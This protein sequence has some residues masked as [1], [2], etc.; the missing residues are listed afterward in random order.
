VQGAGGAIGASLEFLQYLRYLAT[1]TGAVLIIDETMTSRL[2]YHGQIH[3]M[4]IEPDL[5]TLGKW[6]GGGMTFGAFGGKRDIMSMFDQDNGILAHSGT[7]N[8]NV[9][10]MTTGIAGMKIYDEPKVERLN[11]LG[12]L[13]KT[14]LEDILDRHGVSFTAPRSNGAV[15]NGVKTAVPKPKLY[16]CGVGSMLAIHFTGPEAPLL[17]SVFFHHLLQH[18]IYIASRGFISLCLDITEEH[19]EKFADTFEKFVQLYHDNL[20]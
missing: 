15:L 14:R 2:S 6:I 1:A 4:G 5:M 17:K 12:T 8:N 9:F 16:V 13:L 10:S 11:S 7:F 3:K 19:V 18:K 20:Q